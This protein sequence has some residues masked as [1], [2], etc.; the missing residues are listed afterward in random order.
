MRINRSRLRARLGRCA[1]LLLTA[2]TRDGTPALDRGVATDSIPPVAREPGVVGC[3]AEVRSG[4]EVAAVDAR[5]GAALGDFTVVLYPEPSGAP[6]DSSRA[7]SVP[8]AIWHGAPER[9]GRFGLRVT[10][11]GY[12]PWDTA[13]VVVTRDVCHVRTIRL[14]VRLAPH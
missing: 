4:I 13:G 1:V 6:R 9:A 8:P 5:S 3:S 14:A 11:A 7:P 2:C 12:R 10:R